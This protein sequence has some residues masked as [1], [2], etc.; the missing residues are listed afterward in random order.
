MLLACCEFQNP[1]KIGEG[2]LGFIYI[3]GQSESRK[4]K[5][6]LNR[7]ENERVF[8]TYNVASCEMNHMGF[9]RQEMRH[10]RD[11]ATENF[12]HDTPSWIVSGDLCVSSRRRVVDDR[13]QIYESQMTRLE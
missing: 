1:K 5:V 12:N 3:A 2:E 6:R 10:R 7:C 9:L 4:H 11:C 13:T 8:E